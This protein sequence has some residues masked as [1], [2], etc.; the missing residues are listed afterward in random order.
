MN[1]V[2]HVR[3]QFIDA[4]EDAETTASD[5]WRMVGV[6]RQTIW[7]LRTT[8]ACTLRTLTKLLDAMDYEIEIRRK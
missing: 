5:L 6:D 4:M 8:G 7:R 3:L 2:D 1:Q